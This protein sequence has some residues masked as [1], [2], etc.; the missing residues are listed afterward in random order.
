MTATKKEK[1][2]DWEL[3][4]RDYRAGLLSLR[5]IGKVHGVSDTAIRKKAKA[6]GWERDLTE[7]VNEKVRTELVRS[8]VRTANPQ[9]ER[10]IIEAAAATV[11]QVVRGH[12]KH[13]TRQIELVDLLTEQLVDAAGDRENIEKA[14]LAETIT[15]ENS[16][17]YAAMMKAVSL[18]THA[19]TIVSLTNA[20]KTLI[21]LERQAF[22]VKDE[23]EASANP[24]ADLMAQIAGKTLKPVAVPEDDDE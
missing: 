14:I 10:E 22:N 24:L 11:V 19:G 17:R 6:A 20:L 2:T 3:I 13:I 5:E 16:K 1:A 12:R 18:P 21:G 7:K 8:Q 9:T 23:V 4:E 15:D